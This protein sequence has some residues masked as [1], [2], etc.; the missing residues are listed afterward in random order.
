[1]NTHLLILPM[2]CFG[3][4]LQLLY[5]IY[6]NSDRPSTIYGN[7]PSHLKASEHHPTDPCQVNG[8]TCVISY[9]LYGNNPRY[10]N[11]AF[12]N[13]EL[14]P[15]V[16]PGWGVRIYHDDSLSNDVQMKL[17][18]KGAQ[19]MITNSVNGNIAGMF[20]RFFVADDSAVD[21]FI[22]RD[23]DSRLSTREKAAVD[24]WLRSGFP[25][26][27]IRDHPNHD[28]GLNGGLWGGRK[29]CVPGIR[30]MIESF[31]SVKKGYGHD[32]DFLNSVVWPLVEHQTLG[33]DAYTCHKY[34][35]SVSFPT[36]RHNYEIVGGV[37]S[38]DN[39][40]RWSDVQCCTYAKPNPPL[41]RRNASWIYG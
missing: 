36:P 21:Y 10:V 3:V 14:A 16:Y 33:H 6:I 19:L 25:V 32:Q 28:R 17:R 34:P 15:K 40:F 22:V 29:Q 30:R 20:W 26:H 24:E 13:L 9:G 27:S 38:G 1:M 31:F 18:E 41:C 4:V 11:G 35:N 2:L 7:N 39:V 8:S 5:Y 23:L 37:F 12:Y